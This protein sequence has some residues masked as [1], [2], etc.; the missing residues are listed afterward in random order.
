MGLQQEQ[1][2]GTFATILGSD[3]SIRV[4]GE[5]GQPGVEKRDW[6]APD[7]SKGTKFEF[8]YS[9]LVGTVVDVNIYEGDYGKSLHVMIEDSGELYILSTS[10]TSNFASDIMKKLPNIDFK[11]PVKFRPFAFTN[12]DNGKPVKGVTITQ[13]ETKITDFFRD[14]ENKNING[15]PS[16]EGDT[17]KYDTDDWKVYFI[18]VGK[19]LTNHTMEQ[20]KPLMPGTDSL[21]QAVADNGEDLSAAGTVEKISLDDPKAAAKQLNA[22]KDGGETV[23][24]ALGGVDDAFE[25]KK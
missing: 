6:E 5:E 2:K 4:K 25:D 24:E 8:K 21:Q 23:E 20:V 15:M 16:P 9:S 18:Q 22:M 12:K 7:G 19:F 1:I 14:S 17:K 11:L 13:G 3:G 10:A